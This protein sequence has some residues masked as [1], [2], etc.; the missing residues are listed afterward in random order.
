MRV[1]LFVAIFL[2]GFIPAYGLA[3]QD[4]FFQ[5]LYDVPRMAE[6]TEIAD[7]AVFFDKP[8]GRI[9]QALAFAEGVGREDI[10]K[11]YDAVLPQMGWR[12]ISTGQYQR[13]S[14]KLLIKFDKRDEAL[15]VKFTIRPF[16]YE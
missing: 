4:R 7:G 9:A 8:N 2:L 1:Y 13:E 12:P 6:L 15:L 11:F 5:T 10:I 16:S 14:D 3:Q